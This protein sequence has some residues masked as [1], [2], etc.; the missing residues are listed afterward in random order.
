MKWEVKGAHGRKVNQD[1]GRIQSNIPRALSQVVQ[2]RR[3]ELYNE[4]GAMSPQNPFAG[5]PRQRGVHGA[6]AP[7]GTS[8]LS[9]FRDE[10]GKGIGFFEPQ[11]M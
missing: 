10:G 5:L 7:F 8:L 9:V 11:G 4:I 3:E 6:L 2:K 1:A